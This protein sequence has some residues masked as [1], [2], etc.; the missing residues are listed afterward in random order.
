M[1]PTTQ[2]F[3]SSGLVAGVVGAVGAVVAVLLVVVVLVIIVTSVLR[4]RNRCAEDP[5]N[6]YAAV[7]ELN[8]IV[9]KHNE[10]YGTN[11]IAIELQS[12]S[13]Y[14]THT[15][16]NESDRVAMDSNAGINEPTADD[17][18]EHTYEY[19]HVVVQ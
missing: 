2:R 3:D 19:P 14:A 9:P 13:A 6:E 12:N 18:A 5:P 1:A 11:P 10:A 15:G 7:D 17:I 8:V 4:S 16:R